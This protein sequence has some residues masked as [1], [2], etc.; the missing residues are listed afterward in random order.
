MKAY[1]L[2]MLPPSFR[3]FALAF[4][5]ESRCRTLSDPAKSTRFRVALLI[6]SLAL[7]RLAGLIFAVLSTLMLNIVCERED[8]LLREVLATVLLNSPFDIVA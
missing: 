4:L 6:M 7:L 1:L 2:L 5:T 8:L 3:R